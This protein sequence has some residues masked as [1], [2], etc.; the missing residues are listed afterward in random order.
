MA[1]LSVCKTK[2]N[3]VSE[4]GKTEQ[5][6]IR[7]THAEK[8]GAEKLATYLFKKGK[9]KEATVAGAFRLAFHYMV[10]ELTKSIEAGRYS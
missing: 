4:V 3:V 7:V 6:T 2:V 9:L 5:V 1:V 10:N 8:A